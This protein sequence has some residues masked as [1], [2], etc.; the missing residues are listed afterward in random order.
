MNYLRDGLQMLKKLATIRWNAM[1]GHYNK[2]IEA[3]LR[4]GETQ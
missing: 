2:R 3:A 1:T 4:T